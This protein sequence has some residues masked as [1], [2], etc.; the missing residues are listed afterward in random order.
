MTMSAKAAQFFFHVSIPPEEA[1]HDAAGGLVETLPPENHAAL[2]KVLD[3]VGPL[4]PRLAVTNSSAAFGREFDFF[5]YE[6]AY[7]AP[8]YVGAKFLYSHVRYRAQWSNVA[9]E[10]FFNVSTEWAAITA[11]LHQLVR[12]RSGCP[13]AFDALDPPLQLQEVSTD[14]TWWR[15]LLGQVEVARRR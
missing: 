9:W 11:A 6:V 14:L 13:W 5:L 15:W 2:L 10:P 4:T 3:L 7:F 8:G 12:D 1:A